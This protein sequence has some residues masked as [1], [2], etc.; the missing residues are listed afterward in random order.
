MSLFFNTDDSVHI[1]RLNAEQMK[2][3]GTF[4]DVKPISRGDDIQRNRT[5][6]FIN[7]GDTVSLSSLSNAF[8]QRRGT[9]QGSPNKKV[10]F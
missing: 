4:I 5:P 10:N 6:I 3:R 9:F 2:K 8:N 7:Q 1:D